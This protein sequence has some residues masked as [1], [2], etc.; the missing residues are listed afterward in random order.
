MRARKEKRLLAVL[1]AAAALAFLAVGMSLG[2]ERLRAAGMQAEKLRSGV[3]RLEK[4]LPPEAEAASRVERL[5]TDLSGMKT[6]FYAPD[7][8]SS[9]S[10]GTLVKNTLT[11]LGMTVI[12]YQVVEYQ[13]R[14]DL[15]FSVTGSVRSL[16]LFLKGL[17]E[18]EKY[19]SIPSLTMTVREGTDIVDAVFR[20]GYETLD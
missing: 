2:V 15:E 14:K 6:L 1:A 5:R 16:V 12:R 11:S 20:I 4:A 17:S 7:A 13:G 8:M 10:F 9:Y 18:A 3:S 19:S